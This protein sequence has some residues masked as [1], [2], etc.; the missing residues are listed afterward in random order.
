MGWKRKLVRVCYCWCKLFV[1]P[2]ALAAEPWLLFYIPVEENTPTDRDHAQDSLKD[3]STAVVT[4][5]LD[6]A[7][8]VWHVEFSSNSSVCLSFPLFCC[9]AFYG[10]EYSD[11]DP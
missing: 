6:E 7:G 8:D 11:K 9:F 5:R 2:H 3:P 4:L 1:W 10:L